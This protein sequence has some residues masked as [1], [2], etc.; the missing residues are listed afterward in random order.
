MIVIALVGVIVIA[1][2]LWWLSNATRE[3]EEG[4]N[5]SVAVSSNGRTSARA[6]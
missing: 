1:L 5:G 3:E 6:E 2:E 4:N